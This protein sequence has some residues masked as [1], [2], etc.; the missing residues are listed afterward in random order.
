MKLELNNNNWLDNVN[1]NQQWCVE[2]MLLDTIYVII[3]LDNNVNKNQFVYE[4]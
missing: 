1:K 3:R 2:N 4:P